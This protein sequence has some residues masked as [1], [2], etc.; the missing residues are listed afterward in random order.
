MLVPLRVLVR[1]SVD[2]EVTTK[3]AAT[4]L[5]VVD[6]IPAAYPLIGAYEGHVCAAWRR[7]AQ[8]SDER[9]HVEQLAP[10]GQE[11]LVAPS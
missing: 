11:L 8:R 10:A 9:G 7:E 4:G 2:A 3:H 1:R 6:V 5:G